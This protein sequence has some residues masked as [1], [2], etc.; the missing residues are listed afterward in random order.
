MSRDRGWIFVDV[1]VA[2]GLLAVALGYLA[3]AIAGLSG[4]QTAQESRVF[5]SMEA[6]LDDPWAKFR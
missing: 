3:P 5:A 4:L 6:G 2:L 1:L